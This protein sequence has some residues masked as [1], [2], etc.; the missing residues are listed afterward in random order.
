MVSN[1]DKKTLRQLATEYREITELPIQERRRDLWRK[2][3]SFHGTVPLI[4]ILDYAW[5]ELEESR[6][7]RCTNPILRET[8]ISLRKLLYWF[9]LDDDSVFE[10]WLT[11]DAVKTMTG[12][13]I[14]A[15]THRSNEP[16]GAY[17]MD[18]PIKDYQQ[19]L[20]KLSVPH[21]IIDEDRTAERVSLVEE[22]IGDIL[23]IDLNRGPHYYHFWGDI[24]TALGSLRGIENFMQD[25]VDDPQNLHRLCRFLSDGV[26]TVHSEAE[27]SGD[28]GLTNHMNQSMVYSEELEDPA[29]NVRGVKRERLW[30]YMAAQEMECVSPAMHEEFVLQYQIPILESFGLVAYGCCEN[31]SAKID[32]LRKVPN[33]RRIA[34]AP[35]A[36]VLT[37][38]EQIQ[39]D[40]ILSYRPSPSE[41]VGFQFD[42]DFVKQTVRNDLEICRANGCHVDIT[43]KDVETVQSDPRRVREWVKATR[44]V[45]AALYA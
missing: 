23:P 38:A 7:L 9:S 28:W 42:K 20:D 33:L 18:Y 37:C 11:V 27:E 39:E 13:G 14:A 34:V 41:M 5:Q 31:L 17:K 26:A 22:V 19:D 24:S 30:T 3:N 43:L 12:W 16:R 44:E 25:M 4:Y 2:Q 15:T 32:M 40:Y 36:D 35:V 8:E 6:A 21:H 10:P 29:P 45:V 1:E